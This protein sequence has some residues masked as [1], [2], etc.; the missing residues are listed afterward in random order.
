MA[1]LNEGHALRKRGDAKAA[2]AKYESCRACGRTAHDAALAREVESVALAGLG[3]ACADI[4][5]FANV[6]E[7]CN[8]ALLI[9]REI[10]ERFRPLERDCLSNLGTTYNV[11]GQHTEAVAYHDQALI[12]SREIGD[13]EGEG[14]ALGAL[15]SANVSLGHQNL[16]IQYSDQAL[17]I[18]REIGD[19]E[20]ERQCLGNI[21]LSHALQQLAAAK[22]RTAAAAAA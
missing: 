3:S 12:I 20:L 6:I 13:R 15:G 19:Q 2:L 4:G 18:A 10:G 5:L 14:S 9:S 11:L 8:Q 7:H 21:A 22:Q 1:L 16:A 17:A